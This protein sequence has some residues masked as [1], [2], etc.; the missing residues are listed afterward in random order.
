MG[1]EYRLRFAY[2]DVRL[3]EA[4]LR[5][6]PLFAGTGPG[7]ACFDYRGAGNPGPMPDASATIEPGGLYFCDHG[8]EGRRVLA[9]VVRGITDAFGPPDVAEVE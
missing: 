7:A 1:R 6:V 9:Q 4:V 2:A 5:Q 3:V 8:G